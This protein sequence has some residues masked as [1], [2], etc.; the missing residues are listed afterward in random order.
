MALLLLQC[1]L[2]VQEF[3]QRQKG[4]LGLRSTADLFLSYARNNS[5]IAHPDTGDDRS[6]GSAVEKT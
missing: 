6:R 3:F 4:T 1:R 2:E 5:E